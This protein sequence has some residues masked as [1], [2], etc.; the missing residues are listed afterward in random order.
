MT[1]AESNTAQNQNLLADI[2]AASNSGAG[3]TAKAQRSISS[4][5]ATSLSDNFDMFLKLLTTQLKNQDPTNPMDSDKFTQQLTQYSGIEQQV[6]TNQNLQSVIGQLS[7]NSMMSVLGFMN[8]EVTTGG[9]TQ[10][11]TNGS[12]SWK[13]NSPSASTVVA[14]ITITDE[15]NKVVAT[16]DYTI[17][18][19]AQTFQWNGKDKNGALFPDGKYKISIDAKDGTGAIVNVSTAS[20]GIVVGIDFSG[21]SPL[22]LLSTGEQ[23]HIADISSIHTAPAQN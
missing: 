3:V 7:A 20:K 22:L 21:T 11:L 16:Q 5:G 18:P 19:G 9:A 2:A 6:Q 14:K 10:S 12:A 15:Q 23:I 8:N 13:L 1:I 4:L 17:T